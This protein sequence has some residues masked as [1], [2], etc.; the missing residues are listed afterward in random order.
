MTVDVISTCSD[1]NR[2]CGMPRLIHQITTL[3]KLVSASSSATA[4]HHIVYLTE[5][6]YKNPNEISYFWHSFCVRSNIEMSQLT[7]SCLPLHDK[8]Q[9]FD[10][11]QELTASLDC[12][13]C[14]ECGLPGCLC[15]F[16]SDCKY[17]VLTSW[18]LSFDFELI[19]AGIWQP[20][21]IWKLFHSIMLYCQDFCKRILVPVGVLSSK[22]ATESKLA[23]RNR[24]RH[25]LLWSGTQPLDSVWTSVLA[26]LMQWM[27]NPSRGA[28]DMWPELADNSGWQA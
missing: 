9:I 19:Y 17:M 20:Q 7:G 27:R 24:C 11:P 10:L 8:T 13:F 21:M 22:V 12:E 15:S 14:W 18:H 16:C 3:V 26:L 1:S 4:S 6:S 28:V 2:G 25:H 23:M 5:F